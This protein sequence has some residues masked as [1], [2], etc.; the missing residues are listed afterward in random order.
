M[1]TKK[2][3]DTLKVK[4]TSKEF[5]EFDRVKLDE[6]KVIAG[7]DAFDPDIIMLDD[8]KRK[9]QGAS[10]PNDIK[11]YKKEIARLEKKLKKAA[12]K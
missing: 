10:D 7:N 2:T 3:S 12:K 1:G 5:D 11:K 9:L 8:F 4:P 6:T